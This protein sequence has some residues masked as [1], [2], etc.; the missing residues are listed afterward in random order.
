KSVR[1]W[2][3]VSGELR[4]RIEHPAVVYGVAFAADSITLATACFDGSVRLWDAKTG[5][6]RASFKANTEPVY[7]VAFS[8]GG[9]FL[10]SAGYDQP[11]RRW[12]VPKRTNAAVVAGHA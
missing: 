6:E 9:A 12:D 11:I 2:D 10:A 7:C 5:A 1:I 8:R 3:A 4:K